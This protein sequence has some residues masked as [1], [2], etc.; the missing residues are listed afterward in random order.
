V[1]YAGATAW[2]AAVGAPASLGAISAT[3][4]PNDFFIDHAWRGGAFLLG[5][6]AMW[7]LQAIGLPA[8]ARAHGG[9]DS[10]GPSL[11]R[12]ADDIDEFDRW[13]R[14]RPLR[15][16][17]PARP[18]DPAL[19]PF[20]FEILKHPLRDENTRARSV[21]ER[22]GQVRAP[23][24]ILAGWHDLLLAAD[25]QHYRAMREHAETEQAREGTRLVIGPWSHGMF[26]NVVGDVDFG[27]RSSGAFLDLREDLTAMQLRWFGHWL[28]DEAPAAGPDG[29]RVRLFVQGA[30]RWRNADD[31]PLAGVDDRHLHLRSGGG[32]TFEPPEDGEPPDAYAY[33][34]EQPCPTRGGTVLMPRHYPAGPVDQGPLLHRPDVLCFT[35]AP[36]DR[37][38]EVIGHVRAVLYAATSAPDT[39][40]VVK[41]CRVDPGGCTLNVCDGILRTSYRGSQSEREPVKPGVVQRYEVDLWATAIAFAPGEQLRVLV[42]SSDFPRYDRN[43][44]TGELGV[45]ATA[46]VPALQRIFHDREYPSHLVLPVA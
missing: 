5:T 2:H 17:P 12:L 32:L 13:T 45:E 8:V 37:E 40:W 18:D 23:A 4:A 31:W 24:L 1:S 39:D 9:T 29:P 6:L 14:Y 7:S 42:T 27:L 21:S 35:S 19:L 33:D 16:F 15:A 3:T 22:H 11:V 38:L 28:S 26:L 10:F 36:L 41:L 46:S 43:P 30:N 34:P 20:F 44:N 25:L